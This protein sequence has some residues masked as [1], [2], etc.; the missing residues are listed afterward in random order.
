[1]VVMALASCNDN[2]APLVTTNE[3]AVNEKS[4]QSGVSAGMVP[5]LM[6]LT[7]GAVSNDPC[8]KGNGSNCVKYARCRV[9]SFGKGADMTYMEA[10]YDKAGKL[11]SGKK[12]TINSTTPK[13]GSIAICNTALPY[14]HAAWV[15]NVVKTIDPK[16]KKETVLITVYEANFMGNY[17][18]YRTGTATELFIIGYYIP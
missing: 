8:A 18:S 15:K 14:G 2:V 10:K 4:T 9:P 11:L 7:K 5:D 17:I 1:M 12:G 13:I 3:R 6:A 16:T